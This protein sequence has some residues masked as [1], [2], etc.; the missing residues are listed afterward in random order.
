[1]HSLWY[2]YDM[3]VHVTSSHSQSYT[4]CS[5]FMH[6]SEMYPT[7]SKLACHSD[8]FHE[9]ELPQCTQHTL[10]SSMSA[11]NSSC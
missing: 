2:A 8:S 1:M 3:H 7:T 11:C 6:V 10:Q 5:M 4:E 9:W